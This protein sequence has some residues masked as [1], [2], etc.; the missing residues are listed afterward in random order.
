VSSGYTTQQRSG[1][2]RGGGQW[3]AAPASSVRAR[4]QRGFTLVEML[5]V[6]SILGILAAVVS[7]SMAGINA[8]AQRRADDE[9]LMTVQSAMNFMMADQQVPPEVACSLYAGGPEGVTDMAQFPSDQ[10]F[11]TSAGAGGTPGHQPV[12]LWP[13]YLRGEITHRK[14]ACTGGGTV[15]RA[16]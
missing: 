6:I 1:T 13:H 4:G 12:Q 2:G 7:M 10:P 9:E 8:V 11:V 15:T 14:Y 16:G 3:P 5:I